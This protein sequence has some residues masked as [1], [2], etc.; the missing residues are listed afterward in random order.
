MRRKLEMCEATLRSPLFEGAVAIASRLR[1]AGYNALFVGGAP[2]DMLLGVMPKDIDIATSARPEQV[3]SLFPRSHPVGAA[4]GVVTVVEGDVPYEVASFRE[5]R[6]YLDGRHPESVRY[7]DDPELDVLRRDFT[8]NGLFFDPEDGMIVDHVGGIEDLKAGLLRCIGDAGQR[9][10]ED[11]LRMLRAVRFCVRLRM[12]MDA[13]TAAAIKTLAPK[14]KSLSA[15]RVRDELSKMLTG[16]EPSR[17]FRMMREL[18]VLKEVLPEIDALHGVEQPER[19]H[20][21]G[22]VFEHTML[23]LDMTPR[24]WLELAWS[25]LLHD[26]GKPPTFSRGDDGVE[27][28][29]GHDEVGADMAEELLERLKMPNAVIESV[30]LAVRNH[31]KFA[32]VHLMR[33]A[34]WRRLMASPNFPLELELHRI[35]CMASHA[36]MSNYI[37]LLDRVLELSSE[38]ALPPPLLMGRDLIELGMKPGPE[39]G[40]ILKELADLQ[41]E[42]SLKTREDAIKLLHERKLIPSV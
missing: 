34:K 39:M 23:M 14:L 2:R 36:K 24:P 11:Y 26:I 32:H 15:E 37:L 3:S 8:V 31:M 19:H 30:V 17:A 33:Q 27:H 20:P 13:D 28:F 16:P 25:V 21:E 41:L 18:G 42:G 5:E 38:T 29:Y 22:D 4:F 6:E 9:F 7:T 1:E 40:A 35:D 10:S 12:E